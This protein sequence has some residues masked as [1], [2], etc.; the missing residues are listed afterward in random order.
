MGKQKTWSFCDAA[1]LAS[2]HLDLAQEH[3]D[4]KNVYEALT[5]ISLAE[6]HLMQADLLKT[7]RLDELTLMERQRRLKKTIERLGWFWRFVRCIF[8]K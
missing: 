1:N 8:L 4:H 7:G 3:L 5:E 2:K 6:H